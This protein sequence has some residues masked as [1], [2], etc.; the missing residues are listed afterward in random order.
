MSRA[1]SVPAF[2]VE[3]S[4]PWMNGTASAKARNERV[5]NPGRWV[6][7]LR[8]PEFTASSS[9][10]KSSGQITFAGWRRVRST[11]RRASC[12]DLVGEAV[13]HRP[14]ARLAVA[15]RPGALERVTGLGEEDVVER[16]LV[17]LQV[18]DLE[19]LGVERAH[20]LGKVVPRSRR[21]ERRRRRVPATSSPK[22]ARIAAPARGRRR[23]PG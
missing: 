2:M 22:R 6:S 14:M 23:R 16:G 10:G 4:P 9:S 3:K 1:R 21:A 8:P 13:A 19:P 7:A 5:G 15:V 11:E 20:D 17:E 12:S 18:L